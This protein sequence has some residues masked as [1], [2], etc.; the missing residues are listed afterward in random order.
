[1]T[2]NNHHI[3]HTACAANAEIRKIREIRE[4]LKLQKLHCV[5]LAAYQ[6]VCHQLLTY[7]NIQFA[8]AMK[9]TMKRKPFDEHFSMMQTYTLA[10]FVTLG[11]G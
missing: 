11:N 6:T 7:C 2:F 4:L 10:D 3:S 1:M 5:S 9:K 8:A